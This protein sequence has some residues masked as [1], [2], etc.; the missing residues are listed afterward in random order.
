[1]H[2]VKLLK[3]WM[4]YDAREPPSVVYYRPSLLICGGFCL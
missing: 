2:R 3:K 1:M 4:L